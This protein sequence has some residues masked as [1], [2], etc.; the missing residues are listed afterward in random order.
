LRAGGGALVAQ[1]RF[2][3]LTRGPALSILNLEDK[4]APK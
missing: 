1:G 2:L 3:F 4:E